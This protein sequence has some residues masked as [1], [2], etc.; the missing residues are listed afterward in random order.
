MKQT[1]DRGT[2]VID[3]GAHFYPPELDLPDR[4]GAERERMDQKAGKDRLHDADTVITE[5]KEGGYDAMTLSITSFMG[6][7][8]AEHTAHSNDILY[9]YVEEYDEF[10]GLA[11][12][13]IGASGEEAADEFAR[14]IDMGFNGGALHETDVGLTDEEMEPVLE[15]ADNTGAPIFVHIPELPNIEYRF[16]ATFGREH[17]QQESIS[18]V[19]HNEVYDRYPDLN[20]I[21]HHLGGNIASMLGRVHLHADPG[22]WLN[23]EP[24]KSFDE[25]KADLEE[26]VYVDTSGF[27]GYSAPVRIALEEFPST[28]ILFG[29]DFPWEPRSETELEV[30]SDAVLESGTHRDA[31]RILG[32]NALDLMVNV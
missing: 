3:F 4:G 2:T 16:N 8:D 13:P 7:D 17:A 5:M 31:R 6:H 20:I 19:I 25:Y 21:W 15:I 11:S 1:T 9:E 27:F 26:R 22:R 29:T 10:Y 23:Q 12:I 14:C 24:M 18:E 30:L 28:Q 32:E